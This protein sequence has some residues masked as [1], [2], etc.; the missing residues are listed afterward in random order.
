[1]T[2]NEIRKIFLEFFEKKGHAI[3]SSSSL[4]PDDPSVL[5]TTAG[6]QQFKPY[7][8]GKA[9]PVK[10]FK[11]KNTTSAQK[12]FRTSDIDEVGDATHL[13]FFEMLGNFS[14]G[15]YWKEEAIKYGYEFIVDVLGISTDRIEVSIFG[16]ED[17][18]PED[19]ESFEIWHN[20]IGIAKNKIKK[21][22]RKDNFWGPTGNEGPCG[23]TTEIYVDGVEVW[24][25][26]FNE[27]YQKSDKTL[28][29]LETRGIDT[30][31]GLERLVVMMQGV[32]DVY[33][34]DLFHPLISKIR[35]VSHG[36]DERTVRILADHLRSS[37]FAIADGVRPLNK[38]AGYVLR[39]LLRRI[40]VYGI[41]YDIHAD[42]FPLA[43]DIIADNFGGQYPEVKKKKEILEILNGEKTKFEK[44]L[45]NGLKEIENYK[46][47]TAKDAFYIYE[48]FG[49]PFELLEELVPAKIKKVNKADFDEEFKKHQEISRAGVEKK[50]GGHGLLMDTGELKAGS[51]EEMGKVIRLHTATHLL[52]R[53]LQDIFGPS[54]HQMGSDIN[55]ERARFDFSSDRKLT[56]EELQKVENEVNEA[57][58]KDLPVYF[59]EMSQ[60][61]AK[62][63]GAL[64]FFKEKYPPVVKVYFIGDEKNPFSVEFCGGPHVENTLK[65]GKFKILKQEAVGAGVKRIRFNVL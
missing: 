45:A 58:K 50:F 26:V 60:D 31:M 21:A 48:T 63:T 9:D 56:P 34:T 25:I 37:I 44:A 20:K 39:R 15:G 41:K 38:E 36:L 47:I 10:D 42:L 4:V 65:I 35:E 55:P 62:M 22:G 52:Q 6:M 7:Y 28:E 46:E 33:E 57:I 2:S 17:G 16:G 5:F 30:G 29:K 8:T 24:N 53:A 12:C 43:V 1:M 32:P 61:Q 40:L 18:V 54:A 11:S 64:F 59:K 14:F 13:T 23:P 3:V 49:L 51:E 19:K 27:Y